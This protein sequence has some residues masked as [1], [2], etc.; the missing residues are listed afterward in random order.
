MSPGLSINSGSQEGEVK[1]SQGCPPGNR[2]LSMCRPLTASR[3]IASLI[4]SYTTRNNRPTTLMTR[5]QICLDLP[6]CVI[7]TPSLQV[8]EPNYKNED[9]WTWERLPLGQYAGPLPLSPTGASWPPA[10]PLVPLLT[11]GCRKDPA[12]SLDLSSPCRGREVARSAKMLGSRKYI[13]SDGTQADGSP[14]MPKGP[15]SVPFMNDATAVWVSWVC[16]QD[17]HMGEWTDVF[18]SLV[19]AS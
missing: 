18:P 10:A 3:F 4:T 11:W 16:Y 6:V 1:G 7:A 13:S 5:P 17:P 15:A 8:G 19:G 14:G 2:P 12:C 9:G